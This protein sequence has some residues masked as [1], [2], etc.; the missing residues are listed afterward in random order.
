MTRRFYA[1]PQLKTVTLNLMYC[2]GILALLRPLYTTSHASFLCLI[3]TYSMQITVYHG[4]HHDTIETLPHWGR[5]LLGSAVA[6]NISFYNKG[7]S[8]VIVVPNHYYTSRGFF[9]LLSKA[10]NG[11]WTGISSFRARIQI[12]IWAKVAWLRED[13]AITT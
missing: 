1:A 8:F 4:I 6:K 5:Y 12:K 10:K 3:T 9:L 11:F 13:S 2:F 7:K